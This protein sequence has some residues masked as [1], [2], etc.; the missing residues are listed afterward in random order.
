VAINGQVYL[1]RLT[2]STVKSFFKVTRPGKPFHIL[3]VTSADP[4]LSANVHSLGKD[5]EYQVDLVFKGTA[6]DSGFSS[7]VKVFTD[8]ASTPVVV[9]PV[10]G[11]GR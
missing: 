9:V 1:G 7:K 11:S 5:D 10:S 4:R 3:R 6:D 8:D 2:G